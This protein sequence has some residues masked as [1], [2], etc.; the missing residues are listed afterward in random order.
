MRTW[1]VAGNWKMFNTIPE[2]TALVAQLKDGLKGTEGG[3]VVV[4]PAF[5]ALS[6]RPWCN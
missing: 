4:A 1:M 2:A 6:A 5:T 3:E